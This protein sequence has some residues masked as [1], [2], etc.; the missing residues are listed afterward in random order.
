MFANDLLRRPARVEMTQIAGRYAFYDDGWPG[1]LQLAVG[2]DLE[3]EAAFYSYRFHAA[4]EATVTLDH[5]AP[6]KI[7]IVIYNFNELPHQTFTGHLFTRAHNGIAGWTVWKG[8]LF[9][10]LGRKAPPLS[11]G[12]QL[13]REDQLAPGNFSGS[14]SLYCDGEHA[15]LVLAMAGPL[16]LEGTLHETNGGTIFPVTAQVDPLIRNRI[17]ITVH[18]TTE[19]TVSYSPP[20]TLTAYLFTRQRTAMAGWLQ[21]GDT[22]LGCYMVRFKW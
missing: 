22:S 15:T 20:P 14:Y 19:T 16:S 3:L 9:G 12:A 8:E 13:A 2:K 17:T 5:Q 7:S 4:F 1:V 6:H 21:W 18:L 11:L 10:F